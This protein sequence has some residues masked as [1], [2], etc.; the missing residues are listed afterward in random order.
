MTIYTQYVTY[1][2]YIATVF[3]LVYW[4]FVFSKLIFYKHKTKQKKEQGVSI[5]ICAHNEYENLKKN[6]DR[7]LNQNYRSYEIVVVND[8]STDQTLDLLLWY[9]EMHSIFVIVNI[10]QKFKQGKKVALAE[11]IKA[12]KFDTVLLTDADCFPSSNEWITEM[13][14]NLQDEK[15]IILGYGAYKNTGTWLNAFIRF[16]TIMTAIQYMSFALN[17]K[18]YMGVGRNLM[19]KKHLFLSGDA[20]AKHDHIPA[21]DDDLFINRIANKNNTAICLNQ[22]GFT[23]SEGAETL[24]NF[25]VQKNRHYSVSKHY[26][27]TSQILLGLFSFTYFIHISG[28]ILLMLSSIAGKQLLMLT[29]AVRLIITW[30]VFGLIVRRFGEKKLFLRYPIFELLMPIYYVIFTPALMNKFKKWK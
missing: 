27:L 5:V 14:S 19:Y 26:N 22:K 25:Y 9:R 15:E 8:C 12:S 24:R 6:L 18:P 13:V 2:F 23:I 30:A 28:G 20:V 16:E 10:T 21:G 11:G 7:F 17:G 3:Q 4:L 29:Y 1:A